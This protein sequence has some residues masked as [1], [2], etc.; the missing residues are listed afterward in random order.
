M[1]VFGFRRTTAKVRER[2]YTLLSLHLLHDQK[3]CHGLVSSPHVFLNKLLV[4]AQWF[5]SFGW[6]HARVEEK[7]RQQQLW[8]HKVG[9]VWLLVLDSTSKLLSMEGSD[10]DMQHLFK[11][12][13]TS[14][15][16]SV[17]ARK[18]IIHIIRIIHRCTVYIP[19]PVAG[20]VQNSFSATS[21]CIKVFLCYFSSF[22]VYSCPKCSQRFCLDCDLYIHE[23][24]HNCPGCT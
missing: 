17:K 24:L 14:L 4:V 18:H 6:L 22:Q 21:E 2:L 10:S 1:H 13:V 23:T 12:H 19:K 15:P 11:V 3:Q 9:C 16:P 5:F 20:F 8:F 7:N